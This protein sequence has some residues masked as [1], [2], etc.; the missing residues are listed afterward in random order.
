M[1]QLRVRDLYS[2]K[3]EIHDSLHVRYLRAPPPLNSDG[4]AVKMNSVVFYYDVVCPFAYM[5]SRLVEGMGQRANAIV[6]W[7]PVLL[8][9]ANERID[10]LKARAGVSLHF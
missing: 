9:M 7:R 8:G 10:E 6:T 1:I 4:A 5:A 2:C 3:P